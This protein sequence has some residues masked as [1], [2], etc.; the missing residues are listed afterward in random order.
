MEGIKGI[1]RYLLGCP[2][3]VKKYVWQEEPK[4]ILVFTDSNWAGCK[5]TRKSTS[6]GCFMHDKHLLKTYSRTPSTIALSSAE[7]EL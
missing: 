1:G 5:D 6:G 7:A 3:I 4:Q 2:R